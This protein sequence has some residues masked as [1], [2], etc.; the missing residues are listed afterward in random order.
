MKALRKTGSGVGNV[1]LEEVPIPEIKS[2]E[3]LMKVWATGVCGS[4]LLIQDDQHFY[5]APVTLGHEYSG[6]AA[7]V[8][9]DVTRIKKGDQIVSDIET[10]SGWLG[11][12][13]DGSYAPYMAVPEAQVYTYPST[14][15]LDHACFTEPVVAILHCMQ[16]RNNVK[17]GDFVVVVGP[18]PM[19]LLGVQFAKH[20]GARKVALIGLRDKDE[21][22]LGI[23]KK[24][25]ADYILHSEDD[26]AKEIMELTDGKGADF[27]LECSASE[28]GVQHAIDC[29]RRSPEG[30]GGNGTISMISLWGRKITLD[31]DPVSLYQLNINGAWS[32][33]G[34]ES[35]ERAVDLI[36]R[37]VFDLDSLITGRY[38]LEDWDAAFRNL[39]DCQDVKA[40]VH[41]NG[42]NWDASA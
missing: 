42:K 12:T 14:V 38:E 39:R 29:A 40:Y 18:G 11:V 1:S 31:L 28:A 24:V 6:I 9:A 10:S 2:D 20:R 26:P 41:P 22:R 23:G 13:R 15:S 25:G 21:Y 3:V 37:G 4:D 32:W 8:G 19:G 16:E 17:A 27:V 35:W 7:E 34:G 30:P 33:N 5:K 36:S